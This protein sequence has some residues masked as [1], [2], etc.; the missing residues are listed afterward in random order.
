MAR[1]HR[2]L[3]HTIGE[4]RHETADHGY[5]YPTKRIRGLTPI[6]TTPARPVNPAGPPTT[7]ARLL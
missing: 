5:T 4:L 1:A 7:A 3:T 6:A 2:Q